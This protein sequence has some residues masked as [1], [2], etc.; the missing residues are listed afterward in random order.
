MSP[1]DAPASPQGSPA[2]KGSKLDRILLR[3]GMGAALVVALCVLLWLANR[4]VN[5]TVILVTGTVLSVLAVIELAR[6]GTLRGRGLALSLLPAAVGLLLL[7]VHLVAPRFAS[8]DLHP[9]ELTV[10]ELAASYALVLLI[11]TVSLLEVRFTVWTRPF[12]ISLF[13][14]LVLAWLVTSDFGLSAVEIPLWG[15]IALWVAFLAVLGLALAS[16]RKQGGAKVTTHLLAA[17]WVLFPL[18]ALVHVWTNHGFYGLVSLIVLSKIG[19]IAGYYVGNAVGRIHPFPRLSPGKTLEGCLASLAA[20]TLAGA[21]CVLVGWLPDFPFGWKGGLA[22]G[23]VI[24]VAAQAGDLFESR[25]KRKYGVKD[26]G[27]L[28]GPSGGV[29]DV[30]DSLLFTVP[31]ALLVWPLLFA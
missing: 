2:P 5:G 27:W 15:A 25:I 7:N 14:L 29:L 30:V 24:N 10:Y 17:A 22:A 12:L 21:G 18:P 6:M 8:G 23:L 19:D 1:S 11:A 4:S 9:A 3:T 26:S 20:G 31:V 13:A 16:G 28:F